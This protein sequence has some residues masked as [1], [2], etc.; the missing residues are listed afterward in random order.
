MIHFAVVEYLP[1][2][3]DRRPGAE[4]ATKDARTRLRGPLPDPLA[5][6]LRGMFRSLA[7]IVLL[8]LLWFQRMDRRWT[9]QWCSYFWTEFSSNRTWP[10][11]PWAW[12]HVFVKSRLFRR[13]NI[14]FVLQKV[15]RNADIFCP[16]LNSQSWAMLLRWLL[17]KLRS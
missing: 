6:L 7:S 3:A 13:Y 11:D 1:Q 15:I 2:P 10:I 5:S 16:N 14:T 4:D 12:S 17:W 9:C 8:A